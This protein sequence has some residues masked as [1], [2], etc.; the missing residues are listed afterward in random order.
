MQLAPG[1]QGI[2]GTGGDGAASE[3]NT[4]ADLKSKTG[5][6]LGEVVTVKGF[7]TSTDGATHLRVISE[8]NDPTGVLLN[9]GKFALLV[10]DGEVRASRVGCSLNNT[11]NQAIIQGVVQM[12]N[13]HTFIIDLDIK[14]DKNIAINITRSNLTLKGNGVSK[15]LIVHEGAVYDTPIKSSTMFNIYMGFLRPI[16]YLI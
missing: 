2:P 14:F 13:V 1:P 5:L 11:D 12:A 10:H 6:V 4:I 3:I 8:T 9:D 16:I 15:I 7:Y